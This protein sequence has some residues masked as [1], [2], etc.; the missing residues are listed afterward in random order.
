MSEPKTSDTKLE[1]PAKEP[2]STTN[3]KPGR[4]FL[5]RFLDAFL[6]ERSIRWLLTAGAIILFGSSIML[7]QQ[8][9]IDA[10][11]V[12]QYLILL[13]YTTIIVGAG[14]F[15]TK[16][17]GLERTGSVLLA[18]ALLLVPVMFIGAHWL[19]AT[20]SVGTRLALL[21]ATLALAGATARIALRQFLNAPVPATVTT[22]YLALAV[23]GALTSLSPLP[24]LLTG[25]VLWTILVAGVMKGGRHVF[26]LTQRHI[27]LRPATFF[28]FAV[29]FAQFVGVSAI[30]LAPTMTWDTFGLGMVLGAVPMLL[31]ADTIAQIYRQ[32]TGDLF[33]PYPIAV[34]APIVVALVLVVAGVILAATGL[35]TDRGPTSLP[36]AAA[37]AA[38]LV[39]TL[40]YRTRQS[41]LTWLALT[42]AT[43]AYNFSPV[44]FRDIATSTIDS[45]TT[46]IR[47]NKL[48]YALYGLTYL[49]LLVGLTTTV[50]WLRRRSRGTSNDNQ[51]IDHDTTSRINAVFACPIATFA[52]ALSSLLLLAALTHAKSM[53]PVGLAM[54]AMFTI[55]RRVF[56]EDR[57]GIHAVTAM[58]VA[59]LGVIP[60]LRDVLDFDVSLRLI[61]LPFAITSLGMLVTSH[62]GRRETSDRSPLT[63]MMIGSAACAVLGALAW[64]IINVVDVIGFAPQALSTSSGSGGFVLDVMTAIALLA[65]ITYHAFRSRTSA[66]GGAAVV[67]FDIV[68]TT[69]ALRL[70]WVADFT[71]AVTIGLLAQWLTGCIMRRESDLRRTFQSPLLVV[72]SVGLGLLYGKAIFDGIAAITNQTSTLGA[73]SA[74]P[75]QLLVAVWGFDVARRLN[76]I[77]FTVV[78]TVAIPLAT[79]TCALRLGLDAA[80]VPVVAATTAALAL[81]TK[82][83]SWFRSITRRRF[84]LVSSATDLVG[85]AVIA[86][87]GLFLFDASW[88]AATVI[89]VLG[90][91]TYLGST[92]GRRGIAPVAG[93]ASWFG[94]SI[95]VQ[96][97]ASDGARTLFDVTPTAP[98][99]AGIA[100]VA[101]ALHLVH[102]Q[103][104]ARTR[105]SLNVFAFRAMAVAALVATFAF[106]FAFSFATSDIIG[107]IAVLSAFAMLI[108]SSVLDAVH[109]RTVRHAITAVV[110]IGG[111]F[112]WVIWHDVFNLPDRV[113]ALLL[114]LVGMA[115]YAVA[116]GTRRFAHTSVLARSF[117]IG[118]LITIPLTAIIAV[119]PFAEPSS[120]VIRLFLAAGL[121]FHHG[122]ARDSRI[123]FGAALGC[124]QI[125]A[126]RLAYDL[127]LSDPQFYCI[128][129]GLTVM[130]LGHILR[131]ELPTTARS[132][133]QTVGAL[134]ILGSPVFHIVQ[135]SRLHMLG[136]MVI[137][138][139]MIGL[140]IGFRRRRLLYLGTAAL[141]A[142]MIAMVILGTLDYPELTWVVG[143]SLGAGVIGIA[144]FAERHRERLELRLRRLGAVLE[145][146]N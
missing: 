95:V 29:L 5:R 129:L 116:Q 111:A 70:G 68:V 13:G 86:S 31:T 40:A 142:D 94:L 73:A 90:S 139:A 49:P 132:T 63:P 119:S 36:P 82:Q 6:D 118:G 77:P 57:L 124:A 50:S 53:F 38:G 103:L 113:T 23:A 67:F 7:V 47:E 100:C 96:M 117:E 130:L 131:R 84:A 78:A 62:F 56:R 39:A 55:E 108:G 87:I 133:M 64:T 71:S 91:T 20:W 72:S 121:A 35:S 21:A 4:S 145:T 46:A 106:S 99:A 44:F 41:G 143:I 92:H 52:V 122:L 61:P 79:T 60:F 109:R 98:L 88:R 140:A 37:I 141:V 136:L 112:A 128:P 76:Q 54:A 18:L 51:D 69:L 30:H 144:A 127:G 120:V 59:T 2:T 3:T 17:L 97:F 66:A 14:R 75:L 104:A 81:M 26:W 65:L 93:F 83:T 45:A 146:W 28:P 27:D 135:G 115:L 107:V 10:S 1:L 137:S 25:V 34:V 138:L 74:W 33:R 9:W 15:A 110:G 101:A 16:R 134:I 125:A 114:P 105:P 85:L 48:P 8:H 80:H 89:A 102:G 24:P 11:P 32:R 12:T 126:V 42:L 19:G 22:A 43:V 123:A 58:I